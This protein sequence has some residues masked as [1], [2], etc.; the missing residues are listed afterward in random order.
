MT[1]TPILERDFR[2][3]MGS[4]ATG[5]C[6]LSA[7]REDG[8]AIG[9][10]VNSFS[11]VSLDPPLILV[12]LGA[13][14]PRSQAIIGAER[15]A[16]SVLGQN[17]EALS[18]HFAKPSEGLAPDGDWTGGANG[19]PLINGAAATIECD[20][21]TTHKSGD[22]LIVIG[23]VTCVAIDAERPPLLYFRGGYR[24]LS[25]KAG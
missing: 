2:H 24:Q 21:D 4:F 13:D 20:L 15:F 9:M 10:T 3:A 12:C 11:S 6:V 7:T 14:A 5:V 25:P 16:I 1:H 23:R 8:A 19:A 17:Q 18:N 22:H